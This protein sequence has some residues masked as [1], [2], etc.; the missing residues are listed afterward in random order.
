MLLKLALLGAFGD[1]AT[2]GAPEPKPA[3]LVFPR[4]AG[5][6]P[7]FPIEWWYLT[8]Y[9]ADANARPDYGFQLTFFRSRVPQTQA[10]R[11]NFA[12]RHLLFAHAA[13]SDVQGKTLLHDQRIARS[14]GQEP[15]SNPLDRAAASQRDTHVTL[16]NWS[17]RRQGEGLLA[18]LASDEFSLKLQCSPTQPVLLQGDQGWSRK[19]PRPE[20]AS[21]YYSQP[22]LRLEGELTVRGKR[23]ALGDASQAWLDH[24]WSASLLEKPAI[25]WDWIGINLQGGGALT[26]FR[27]RDAGGNTLWDGGSFRSAGQLFIFR[28]GEV[29]FKSLRFWRSAQS[30]ANY[31][32]EWLVRTPAD[33]YTVRALFDNQELDSRNSTGTIYWEGL[34]EVSNSNQQLVGR[35]Y[36]E[37]TGYASPLRL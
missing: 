19:G 21:Y 33:F 34:C 18:T 27:M 28:P 7:D 17:L 20:N 22:H 4:D 6:H 11:S 26:A 14:S 12:A 30:G 8:G 37:M 23:V 24:E 15:D 1:T 32:V 36:L 31:P 9:C 2:A 10:M 13:I 35:G 16:G 3:A 25:G 5:S 29:I